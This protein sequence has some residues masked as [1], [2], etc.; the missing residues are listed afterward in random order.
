MTKAG[1]DV[2][3][4]IA[5]L[6]GQEVG[7]EE[8]GIPPA[9]WKS[10]PR[11]LRFSHLITPQHHDGTRPAC[12]LL[13]PGPWRYCLNTSTALPGGVVAWCWLNH[14]PDLS[15]LSCPSEGNGKPSHMSC[16]CDL[17]LA[18]VTHYWMPLSC[19][20]GSLD[21]SVF[22]SSPVIPKL[23][24]RQGLVSAPKLLYARTWEPLCLTPCES[25]A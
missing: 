9:P 25:P 3:E 21:P 2:A 24:C 4:Q 8:T 11:D 20:W 14:P 7:V 6:H 1:L 16:Y 17:P 12:K 10:G 15:F 5:C 19:L 18:S 13:T 23:P 22:I